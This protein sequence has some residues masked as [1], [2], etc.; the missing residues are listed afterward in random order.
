[1]EFSEADRSE[2]INLPKATVPVMR[3]PGRVVS[4]V[5]G[6]PASYLPNQ[7]IASGTIRFRTGS[8]NGC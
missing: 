3:G 8:G 6:E 7:G 5:V 4:P 2:T 1:M